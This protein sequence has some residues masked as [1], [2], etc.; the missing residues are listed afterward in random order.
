MLDEMASAGRENL[1]HE[2]VE[3]YDTKEDAHA[4]EEVAVLTAM[5][6]NANSL[7][8]EFGVG[9]GQFAVAIAP[10]CERVVAVDVSPPMLQRLASKI[11]DAGLNN[12]EVVQA[13][14]L[15]YEH[16]GRPADVVYSRYALHHLPDF[17]KAIAFARISD[18]LKPGGVLR[19]WDVVYNFEPTNAEQQIESWCSTGQQAAMHEPLDDGWGRWELEEHVRDEHSTYT[20][21]LEAM[22]RRVGFAVERAE[23]SDDGMFAKYILRRRP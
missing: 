2:H 9:T 18:M 22:A 5:G 11:A 6:L 17:W 10:Q 21:L 12:I 7:V 14:F 23:Y 13:G 20:W 4:L 19:L 15:T 8:V 16:H 1:D 3:R